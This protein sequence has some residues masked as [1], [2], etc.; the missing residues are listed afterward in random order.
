MR[1]TASIDAAL[2]QSQ[3]TF[4]QRR[5]LP[6]P[7]AADSRPHLAARR[8]L[9]CVLLALGATAVTFT[10]LD[11]L[12][13]PAHL[14][15]QSLLAHAA[16]LVQTPATEPVREGVASLQAWHAAAR[17]AI[18]RQRPN[19][20]AALRVLA[21]LAMAQ[22]RAAEA[23][24]NAPAS[25][26]AWQALFDSV[27]ATTLSALLP[28]QT[29]EF[30][31]LADA[32][33]AGR[34][35]AAARA[36]MQRADAV[37]AR[38]AREAIS[39]AAADGFD[40][41]WSGD[42]PAV[43]TAWRSLLQPPR[44]PHLPALGRMTPVFLAS[45][46]AIRPVAPPAVGSAAFAQALAEVK[47]RA[48]DADPARV[49]RAKRWEMVTGSLVAGFWDETATHL[50]AEHGLSGRQASRALAAALGATLDANIACHDA[51]YAY[52][53][54]RPSQLD[55]T[56]RPLVG[57]PNHPSYP[58]NHA[59]D[60]GA[61][62]EVLGAYFPVRRETLRA[63]ARDAGESRIDGGIHYRFD[64]SAGFEIAHAAAR[65]ALAALPPPHAL[66]SR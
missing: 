23:F 57:L 10:S 39:R 63:M 28:A 2:L 55:P 66:E 21:V 47:A 27:S 36:D 38:T 31:R 13:G 59:C 54:P 49:E 3:E 62:A 43:P 56:I 20:Q 45:G 51:K 32:L 5:T 4:M 12:A 64:I 33:S 42:A 44:P 22:H 46:D 40:A 7:P 35:R 30:K 34:G 24:A 58:S 14:G 8:R 29:A 50:I 1:I 53:T 61:A 15:G 19:Q 60:S 16:A 26:A 65:A 37:A 41:P 9:A 6:L 17:D 18:A 52:W 25:D 11:A 48:A